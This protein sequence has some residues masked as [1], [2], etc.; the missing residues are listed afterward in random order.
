MLGAFI[1]VVSIVRLVYFIN[2]D[3]KSPDLDYNFAYGGV[4]TATEADMAV[5]CACLPS[6][7]PILSLVLH[8]TPT[9]NHYLHNPSGGQ[10]NSNSKGTH[11]ISLFKKSHDTSSYGSQTGSYAGQGGEADTE[12]QRGF[13]RLHDEPVRSTA[14]ATKRT[15][16]R[17]GS[18]RDIEMGGMGTERGIRVKNEIKQGWVVKR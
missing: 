4:W 9:A 11:G 18:E 5:V 1:I 10:T 7:R 17:D 3:L 15:E 2:V 6:L 12:S 8:G 14:F 13:A 16:G